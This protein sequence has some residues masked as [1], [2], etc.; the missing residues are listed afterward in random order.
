MHKRPRKPSASD[1]HHQ[2]GIELADLGW[3][4]ESL[5][6]FNH[7]I[8][9][10]SHSPFLRINRASVHFELGHLIEALEDLLAAR[11]LAPD[12]PDTRYHLGFFLSHAGGELALRELISAVQLDPEKIDAVLDLGIAYS[13]RGEF[14]KAE[15]WM[16]AALAIDPND[17]YTHH[18]FGLL[19]LDVGRVHEAIEHLKIANKDLPDDVEVLLDLGRAYIQAGFLDIGEKILLEEVISRQKDNFYARYCLAV[20]S[21]KRNKSGQAFDHILAMCKI[22]KEQARE[23]ICQDPIFDSI[24]NRVEIES[25]LDPMKPPVIG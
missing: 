10:D 9:L 7:A 3:L 22:D 1:K 5:H 24:R 15:E 2:R 4:E 20:V 21:V 23:W 16:K 14:V 13:E 11:R 6:E 8:Q 17:P 18:E 25:L 12:H 19:M